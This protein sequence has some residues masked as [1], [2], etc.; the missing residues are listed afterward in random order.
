MARRAKKF[1]HCYNAS[2]FQL[3]GRVAEE[4]GCM[5]GEDVGYV[6]RF[7]DMT[8]RFTKIKV[9]GQKFGLHTFLEMFQ[10]GVMLPCFLHGVCFFAIGVQYQV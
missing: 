4:I 7:N 1:G 6:V 8:S 10:S 3:A 5:L 9:S 2:I